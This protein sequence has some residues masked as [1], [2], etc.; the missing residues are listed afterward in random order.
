M[1]DHT[2]VHVRTGHMYVF[3]YSS[4]RVEVTPTF[5]QFVEKVLIL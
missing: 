1:I 3:D 4:F 2:T 5:N